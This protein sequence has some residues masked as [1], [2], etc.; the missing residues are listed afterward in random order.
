[1]FG[2]RKKILVS[3]ISLF[4]IFIV[5][6]F[7]FVEKTVA[8]IVQQF[9]ADR[10]TELVDR[11]RKEPNI[12]AMT[13]YLQQENAYIF[14]R[15]T[16]LDHN[17]TVLYD[18]RPP[19]GGEGDIGIL[20][21]AQPEV[22][23]ALKYGRGY[24]TRYS[25]VFRQDIAYMAVA[26]EMD[27]EE[28]VLRVGLPFAELNALTHDFGIG[29]LTLGG[30][31]L[32]LYSIMTWAIMHRLSAPIQQIITAIE[33]YQA[34]K[35]EYLP[36]IEIT[37]DIQGSDEFSKLAHTI[38]S[39]NTRIQKQ[40]E[41]LVRQKEE[42]EALLEA[43]GE[44]VIAVDRAGNVLFANRVAKRMLRI[45]KEE[46]VSKK[47]STL[48]AERQKLLD[49]CSDLIRSAADRSEIAMETFALEETNRF[50]F[51]LIASPLAQHSGIILV[52]QDKTSDYRVVEMGKDFIANASH[53]LRTPI[54]IIR[55][56]AETLI[57]LPELSQEILQEI[58]GKI[59]KTCHRLDALVKSLLTLTD[60]ENFNEDRLVPAD[61]VF[62]CET[63]K[64]LILAAHPHTT[65]HFHPRIE[66]GPILADSDLLEMAVMNLLQNAVKYSPAP[67]EINLTVQKEDDQIAIHVEDKGIGIPDADL[68]HIFDR[69]YTVDKARSRKFGGT[70]LGLSIVKTI[71]QRHRGRVQVVSQLGR[72][73]TFSIFLPTN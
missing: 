49:K 21:M 17:A 67:A 18:T 16:L 3:D 59:V 8:S 44:G 61:A 13:A 53:E 42:T 27:G 37:R 2:F 55:G 30:I 24:S 57:D 45:E 7:P 14:Y 28:Y 62:I 9:L 69:F 20:I 22:T 15:I 60:I 1:M 4:L 12:D 52:L 34:G 10:A 31:I 58:T 66:T 65:I 70:G 19:S 71:V 25:Q 51:D 63:C 73:S 32:M 56:F 43:L 29:F 46:I 35:Q 11:I 39:L 47:F 41:H 5:L 26:F 64:E 50:Y 36:R 72:G 54:T 23:E 38:N 40:F 68:P 33:P 6:L 48:Q